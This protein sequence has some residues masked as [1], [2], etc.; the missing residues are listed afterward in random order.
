MTN[1]VIWYELLT[2]EPTAAATFY[3]NVLGWHAADSGQ[4]GMDYR[5]LSMNGV[6]V[7]GLMPI[8]PG[9]RKSGMRPVWLSYIHV[10]NVDRSVA[11]I[12]A[13]GGAEHM[14]PMDIPNVGRTAM[15]ADP[16]G[17]SFYIMTPLGSGPATSF[18]PG[19]PGHGGWHELHTKDWGAALAFYELQFG[20]RKVH[21]MSMGPLGS[22]LQFN[23]GSGEMVGGMMNDPQAP[24]P[25]WLYYFNVGAV[26]LASRLVTKNGGE[27]LVKPMQVPTGDWVIH[28]RDPQGGIFA[29]VGPEK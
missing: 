1:G 29:L 15:V 14:P 21:E 28:A 17:A 8:P 7:G 12:V 19:T 4:P 23:F 25:Y 24:H 20:W 2:T 16:Q 10:P 11:S 22:Y 27:V 3:R 26:E 5:I 6:A 18:A 13:G 9:A